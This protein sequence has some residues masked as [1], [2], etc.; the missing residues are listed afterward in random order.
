MSS[1]R[2]IKKA[3]LAGIGHTLKLKQCYHCGITGMLILHGF[4]YGYD[5]Y[6]T[7]HM[8]KGRRVFCSNRNKRKGCG[9]TFSYLVIDF[10]QRT[11]ISTGI[12]WKFLKDIL[13]GK[14]IEKAYNSLEQRCVLSLSTFFRF[15]KKFKLQVYAIRTCIA[16]N[17]PLLK[18]T[19]RT[20]Y[21]E[22]IRHL[23]ILFPEDD[24]NPIAQY[25][26]LSQ[27]SFV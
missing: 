8:I 12:A 7:C 26:K 11:L 23:S 14:S 9:H 3:E 22:T 19:E 6:R 16:N 5:E 21:H 13:R 1:F 15:W 25:Q 17:Y 27:T 2:F 24:N 18:F 10:I 4:I 20:P